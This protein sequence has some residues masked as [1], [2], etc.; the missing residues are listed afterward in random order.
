MFIFLTVREVRSNEISGWGAQNCVWALRCLRELIH[1]RIDATADP[2]LR[3]SK[4]TGGGS[5]SRVLTAGK[6]CGGVGLN[7]IVILNSAPIIW[8]LNRG[9]SDLGA[10]GREE[11]WLVCLF[12]VLHP[13]L[14]TLP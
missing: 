3:M 5:C 14:S 10:G 1:R 11:E 6:E 9:F 12:R 8:D 4:Q 2:V 13:V 7:W